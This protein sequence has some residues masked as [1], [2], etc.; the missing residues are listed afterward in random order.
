MK[1]QGTEVPAGAGLCLWLHSLQSS[2]QP[3]E[4]FPDKGLGIFFW[5]TDVSMAAI[6]PAV[7]DG[8]FWVPC[9]C[10]PIE[11]S[12][13][14][15]G[16]WGNWAVS[17][18]QNGIMYLCPVPGGCSHSWTGPSYSCTH[19]CPPVFSRPAVWAC[20][21]MPLGTKAAAEW[22][23]RQDHS[24]GRVNQ[25]FPSPSPSPPTVMHPQHLYSRPKGTILWSFSF[26]SW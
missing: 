2:P 4:S 11:V 16:N 7:W 25:N 17:E 24:R 22:V 14:E 8:E 23:L 26:K 15:L 20:P 5:T 21:V 1:S 10:L 12:C 6:S 18:E 13:A 19:S 9:H 3:S